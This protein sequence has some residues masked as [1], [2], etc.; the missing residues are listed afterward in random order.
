MVIQS[1]CPRFS[2]MTLLL[3]VIALSA[4]SVVGGH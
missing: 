2:S 4:S 1:A 3:S